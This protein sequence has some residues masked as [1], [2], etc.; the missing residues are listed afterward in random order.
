MK[1]TSLTFTESADRISTGLAVQT[2]TADCQSVDIGLTYPL[3]SQKTR[4]DQIENTC[5][6]VHDTAGEADDRHITNVRQHKHRTCEN[7]RAVTYYFA[8]CLA[9]T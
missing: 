7:R 9:D 4:N 2:E 6:A 3:A 8:A 1:D 5:T